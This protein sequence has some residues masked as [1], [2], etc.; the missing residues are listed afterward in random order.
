[1]AK[2]VPPLTLDRSR[3]MTE[4]VTGSRYYPPGDEPTPMSVASAEEAY[5]DED[6]D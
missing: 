4:E 1:M 2:A 3:K 6:D 5:D